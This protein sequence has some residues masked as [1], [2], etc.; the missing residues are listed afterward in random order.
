[1]GMVKAHMEGF[2]DQVSAWDNTPGL[3]RNDIPCCPAKQPAYCRIT[4]FMAHQ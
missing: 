4:W 3:K 2:I 1:M